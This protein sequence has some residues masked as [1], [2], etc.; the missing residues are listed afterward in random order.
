M[1][2][3]ELLPR[4]E[5]IRI[6]G[7]KLTFD[8][9]YEVIH[10]INEHSQ[11]IRNK[12]GL[13]LDLAYEIR[14]AKDGERKVLRPST[15]VLAGGSEMGTRFGCSILWPSILIQSRQLRTALAFM[16]HNKGHQAVVYELEWVIE[17]AIGRQFKQSSAEIRELWTLLSPDHSFLEENAITRVYQYAAWTAHHRKISLPGLLRSLNPIYPVLYP[18]WLEQGATDLISPEE[19]DRWKDREFPGESLSFA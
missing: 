11:I 9:F 7:D 14:K 4:F 15:D 2:T 6:F 16:D 3:Y 17:N 13:L 18:M 10:D 19:Y 5:G 1:L 12:E 8:R